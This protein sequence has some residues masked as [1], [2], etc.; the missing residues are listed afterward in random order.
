MGI[1]LT[2]SVIH[3]IAHS[4]YSEKGVHVKNAVL[5]NGPR[6]GSRPTCRACIPATIG[7]YNFLVS[8]Y[9]MEEAC[10]SSSL[11]LWQP[12]YE[13]ESICVLSL[14]SMLVTETALLGWQPT[15]WTEP[16]DYV[17]SLHSP[18][19]AA[20]HPH[21][22]YSSPA[23]CCRC[24]LGLRRTILGAM[25]E[26]EV[27]LIHPLL[28]IMLSFLLSWAA[29]ARS[30]KCVWGSKEHSLV[31]PFKNLRFFPESGL[32]LKTGLV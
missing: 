20:P 31:N 27:I 19:S 13:I 26:L 5:E 23:W 22:R 4:K 11:S 3:E 24:C 6:S 21:S 8:R 29:D 30:W 25:S 9:W 16:E 12:D 28:T 17:V 32:T 14:H 18:S 7:K 10:Q 1:I 15:V 2:L